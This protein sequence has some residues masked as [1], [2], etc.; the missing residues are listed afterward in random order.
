MVSE[1]FFRLTDAPIIAGRGLGPVDHTTNEASRVAVLSYGLWQPG[2]GDPASIGKQFRAGSVVHTVVGVLAP[3]ATYPEDTQLFLPLVPSRFAREDLARRDNLIFESL[4]LMTR[5][6]TKEQADA[7]LRTIA[8][9]LEQDDP[10]RKGWTNGVVPLREYMVEPELKIALYVLLA[11]VGAVL[12]IACANLANLTLVRGAGRA[13]EM[14]LRFAIG[15]SRGR[16]VRQLAAESL[17]LA[18][19]GG[20]LGIA[21]AAVA[22]NALRAL[23]PAGAPFLDY[24]ALDT[25]VLVAAAV[26]TLVTVILVGLL[27]AMTASG[28]NLTS[29]LKEGGRGSTDGRRIATLRGGLV[30]AEIAIA[31]VLLVSAGL[32]VRSLDRLTATS[33]GAD[34]DRV[35]AARIGVPGARYAPRNERNSTER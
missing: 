3:R 14:G 13:R 19:A 27:P 35:L 20:G 6:V 7:K 9:R 11:A 30:V 25:R 24:V 12:L 10:A 29:A 17:V 26:V 5:G 8:A 2:R 31:V 28:V 1:D 22:V 4:A 23:V 16:L 15:A 34:I 33:P 21:V 32:L 18:L